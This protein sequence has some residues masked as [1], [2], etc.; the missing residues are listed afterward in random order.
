MQTTIKAI[1]GSILAA[2]MLY[3]STLDFNIAV[4]DIVHPQ[5][6][7]AVSFILGSGFT[8]YALKWILDMDAQEDDII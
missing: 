3:L 8:I 2:L 5:F 6:F 7:N 1:V 4:N